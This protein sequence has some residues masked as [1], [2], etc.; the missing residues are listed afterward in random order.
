MCGADC[1]KK[2]GENQDPFHD[3][4][5]RREAVVSAVLSGIERAI[6]VGCAEDSA[7]YRTGVISRALEGLLCSDGC[8]PQSFPKGNFRLGNARGNPAAR[9]PS[10][11]FQCRESRGIAKR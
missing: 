3:R 10:T 9:V 8:R 6:G 2:D 1:G 11:M 7:R 4:S 5:G